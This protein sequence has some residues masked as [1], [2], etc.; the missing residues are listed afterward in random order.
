[1]TDEHVKSFFDKMVK[2]GLYKADLDY[3][4]SY[5]TAFVN[6]KV[7]MD[8]K[9]VVRRRSLAGRRDGTGMRVRQPAMRAKLPDRMRIDAWLAPC[10]SATRTPRRL[11]IVRHRRP[12]RSSPCA[13]SA[14]SF[15]S[16]TRGAAA[17]STSTSARA[18]SCRCSGRPAAASRRRCASSPASARPPPARSAWAAGE[19][20]P[21][22]ATSASSSRSRR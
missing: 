9:Q 15:S 22:R 17:I 2:A 19:R 1:M 5:T 20:R 11:P 13:M 7:G 8:V 6:K 14:R 18:R 10:G 4:K 16:G 3:K 21:S 12:A